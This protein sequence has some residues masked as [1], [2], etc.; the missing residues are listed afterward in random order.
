[1]NFM[2]L[3]LT[4]DGPDKQKL[5]ESNTHARAHTH[6]KQSHTPTSLLTLATA[7]MV[8]VRSAFLKLLN[9]LS[10]GHVGRRLLNLSLVARRQVEGFGY[11]G[12]S[13]SLGLRRDDTK[14]RYR[15]M[16]FKPCHRMSGLISFCS[17]FI[18]TNL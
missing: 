9:L 4:G 2:R 8:A 18:I 1:M 10:H 15:L 12:A 17:L 3:P 5:F 13:R 11:C 6:K 16:C 7:Q 14:V